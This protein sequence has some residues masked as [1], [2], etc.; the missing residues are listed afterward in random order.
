MTKKIIF[1][2]RLGAHSI[3]NVLD[4]IAQAL[5]LRGFEV[6]YCRMDDG[7][8]RTALTPPEGINVVDITV[9][10][11]KTKLHFI[12]Q[13]LTWF[14]YF[15]RFILKFKPDLTHTNFVLPGAVSRFACKIFRKG[16]VVST[17]HE[18]K[19]SMNPL[20]KRLEQSTAAYAHH[21]VHISKVVENSYSES[22]VATSII[23]NGIDLHLFNNLKKSKKV[24]ECNGESLRVVCLGRMVAVKGQIVLIEA[25]PHLLKN[26]PDIEVI[27]I[28]SGSEESNLKNRVEALD[29]KDNV[30]FMGWLDRHQAM[31]LIVKSG[32][33]VVPTGA[34]QEGF[35]L[36]IIEALALETPLICSDI[37]IFR[38]VA[39][40]SALM[41]KTGD[42]KS[43]ANAIVD[44]LDNPLAAEKRTKKGKQRVID[45]FTVNTM[46]DAYIS[47]YN[48]L[49]FK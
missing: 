2:D 22:K 36:A 14:F 9:P 18:L 11:A 28:G 4:P 46:V 10:Y 12:V 13:Q 8:Q 15:S 35:G 41:F 24:A 1:V 44:V 32:V 39:G 45:M 47:L 25:I 29:L 48:N 17:R 42:S 43:L 37:P 21:I 34:A 5:V 33:M 19:Q 23:H 26:N 27:F 40:E 31:D 49:L 16:R 7:R 6:C 20:L 3:W 38:E 30:K